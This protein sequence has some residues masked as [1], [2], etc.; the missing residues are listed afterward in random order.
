MYLTVSGTCDLSS[1]VS[2]FRVARYR[3]LIREVVLVPEAEYRVPE[4]LYPVLGPTSCVQYLYFLNLNQVPGYQK[5]PRQ[6]DGE[7]L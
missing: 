2:Q 6:Q 1:T 7:V 5:N 4:Y 3:I